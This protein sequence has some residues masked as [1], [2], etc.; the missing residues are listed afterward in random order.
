M[1]AG[2][3]RINKRP[4]YQCPHCASRVFQE[5][6]EMG[7]YHPDREDIYYEVL[8][9]CENYKCGYRNNPNE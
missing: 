1:I 9:V 5:P 7:D 3:P 8:E 6:I 4:L 2:M